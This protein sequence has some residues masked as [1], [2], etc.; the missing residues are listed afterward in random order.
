MRIKKL[1][2]LNRRYGRFVWEQQQ[3]VRAA[4]PAEHRRRERRVEA[5]R[6]GDG[7]SLQLRHGQ[8]G[9][10]DRVDEENEAQVSAYSRGFQQAP[11][12]FEEGS[13]RELAATLQVC[14]MTE[15]ISHSLIYPP[16]PQSSIIGQVS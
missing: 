2:Q 1:I 8:E 16:P 13:Q 9:Q 5:P 12:R 6:D 7:A 3:H 10:P 4:A 14:K 11:V 15:S